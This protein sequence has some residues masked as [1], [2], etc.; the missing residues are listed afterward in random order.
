MNRHGSRPGVSK[1]AIF[2]RALGVT[3]LIVALAGSAVAWYL[4]MRT[5]SL[6]RQEAIRYVQTHTETYL[7]ETLTPAEA[8]APMT[9]EAYARVDAGVKSALAGSDVVRVKV[10]N[11]AGVVT[12]STLKEQIGETQADSEGVRAA[13]RGETR[14]EVSDAPESR[15][16][17]GLGTL[18]EVYMPLT[19]PS[20]PTPAAVA[21][22]YLHYEPYARLIGSLRKDVLVTG[23]I[24]FLTLPI[25]LYLLYRTAWAAIVVERDQTTQRLREVEGLN[26]LLQRDVA[27]AL[28]LREGIHSLR[29]DV[30]HEPA[31][32][33]ELAIHFAFLRRHVSELAARA[34][35][36]MEAHGPAGIRKD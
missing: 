27:Y 23:L 6:V 2:F 28:E 25:G 19:W 26:A 18:L 30:L 4:L 10:W 11:P 21:E 14:W 9:G 13:L 31:T 5:E 8:A 3:A 7:V 15:Y 12:Y 20:E 24:V 29:Q 1:E 34:D 32:P 17:Q 36:F 35:R 33:D 22:V 16:E